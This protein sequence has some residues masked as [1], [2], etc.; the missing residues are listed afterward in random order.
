MKRKQLAFNVS[1]T[2][3]AK[4]KIEAASRGLGIKE[5]VIQC[6]NECIGTDIPTGKKND[7]T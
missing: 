4:I 1:E 2:V 7:K 6:I 5:F 3:H